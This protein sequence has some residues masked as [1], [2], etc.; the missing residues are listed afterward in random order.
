MS[1]A[2]EKVEVRMDVSRVVSNMKSDHDQAHHALP[3]NI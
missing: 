3:W 2:G 1:L